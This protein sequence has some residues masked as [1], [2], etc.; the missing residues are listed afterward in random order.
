M[1]TMSSASVPNA[2]ANTEE[3]E[4]AAL[5]QAHNYRKAL[6][7]E[8]FAY[9]RGN[10]LEVGA[11]IGQFSPTIRELPGV[12]RLLSVE[13]DPKFLPRLRKAVPEDTIVPG[14]AR[15]VPPGVAWD[16]IITINV[17]EHIQ[18]DE[19]ELAL[20]R[21]LLDKT[22]GHLCLFVPASPEIYA[23]IDKDFGHFRR[24]TKGELE[25]K[26]TKAGFEIVSL[27]YY[28]WLGYFAW[29]FGFRCLRQRS[30]ARWAVRLYD[31]AAFPMVHW[32]ETH[33]GAPPFGQS[34]LL[35][36]KASR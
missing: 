14:T 31:Q 3:F 34:L 33:L 23:P 12:T 15:D 21:E 10:I 30:F 5:Q 16:A 19:P 8:F 36:A 11:G 13:P 27:R 24:Y 29:W 4:F 22:S 18:H 17:L 9:L 32:M 6:L 25:T 1:T 35:I 20:Y 7:A 28:N 2:Q 26:V